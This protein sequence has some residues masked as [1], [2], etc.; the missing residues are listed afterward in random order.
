M[1]LIALDTPLIPNMPG[2][3]RHAKRSWTALDTECDITFFHYVGTDVSAI[4]LLPM[5]LRFFKDSYKC[6]CSATKAKEPFCCVLSIDT[7][8][9][10]KNV[11]FFELSPDRSYF[12]ASFSLEMFLRMFLNFSNGNLIGKDCSC[13]INELY[14]E[15]NINVLLTIHNKNVLKEQNFAC[16]LIYGIM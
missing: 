12:L 7:I 13:H 14:T 4:H 10:Y 6:R 1:T 11:Q 3:I 9:F 8:F 5:E 2:K 16:I 15:Y